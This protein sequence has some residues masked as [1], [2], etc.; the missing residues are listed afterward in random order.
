MWHVDVH[1]HHIR[2]QFED[3]PF[4]LAR[5]C[6]NLQD[7]Q[8]RTKPFNLTA[9]KVT[10]LGFVVH[11]EGMKLSEP[12]KGFDPRKGLNFPDVRRCSQPSAQRL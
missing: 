12:R 5:G 9:E 8:R 11:D 10:A 4:R 3:Q 2:R 1:E 6:R 7:I